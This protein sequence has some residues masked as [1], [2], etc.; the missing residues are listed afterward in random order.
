VTEEVLYTRIFNEKKSSF[1]GTTTE[2]RL[3]RET[4]TVKKS[5]FAE[6]SEKK[7]GSLEC[8]LVDAMTT[9]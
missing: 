8:Q 2:G 1:V 3:H 9:L 4:L 7:I 5:S 6:M